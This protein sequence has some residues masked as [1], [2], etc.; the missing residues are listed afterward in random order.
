MMTFCFQ[1]IVFILDLERL[2]IFC[3]TNS[4]MPMYTYEHMSQ[5]CH[6]NDAG[7]LDDSRGKGGD[8]N[9]DD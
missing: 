1:S 8:A 9:H 2:A 5:Y 7:N 3:S 4:T 6:H